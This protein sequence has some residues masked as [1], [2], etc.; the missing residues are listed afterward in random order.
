MDSRLS[1]AISRGEGQLGL[2]GRRERRERKD[3]GER[4]T[5]ELKIVDFSVRASR[6]D[7]RTNNTQIAIQNLPETWM[8]V[9]WQS[10]MTSL[11]DHNSSTVELKYIELSGMTDEDF[12]SFLVR[13]IKYEREY[14]QRSWNPPKVSNTKEEAIYMEGNQQCG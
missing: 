4:E 2:H 6:R 14:K 3:R 1:V 11:K 10:N 5:E 13:L 9:G 12:K 7:T 8:G